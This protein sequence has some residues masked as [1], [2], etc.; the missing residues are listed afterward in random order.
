LL[1]FCNSS[2][3][4]LDRLL[5]PIYLLDIGDHLVVQLRANIAEDIA[6]DSSSGMSQL[7]FLVNESFDGWLLCPNVVGK[8]CTRLRQF[9]TG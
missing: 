2:L 6:V 9:S 8:R 7:V 5:P 1:P 4:L 3:P